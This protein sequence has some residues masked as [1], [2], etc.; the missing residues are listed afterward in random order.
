VARALHA[1]L[2]I[3][4]LC[5]RVPGMVYLDSLSFL[6]AFSLAIPEGIART[7]L[8]GLVVGWWNQISPFYAT[9]QSGQNQNLPQTELSSWTECVPCRVQGTQFPLSEP[10]PGILHPQLCGLSLSYTLYKVDLG[11]DQPRRFRATTHPLSCLSSQDWVLPSLFL[12][13][14]G[15]LPMDP[16]P[17]P[18]A[19][20][21][22]GTPSRALSGNPQSLLYP[23]RMAGWHRWHHL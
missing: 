14:C 19:I 17:K 11:S 6:L 10:R 1:L 20:P 7:G 22:L 21:A 18:K 16:H 15:H 8:P 2:G 12:E 4:L 9:S 3:C 23:L 5:R 13:Q